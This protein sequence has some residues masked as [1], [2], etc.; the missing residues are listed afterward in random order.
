M[1]GKFL[2]IFF[3]FLFFGFTVIAQEPEVKPLTLEEIKEIVESREGRPLFVNIWATWCLP[4]KEEFPDIVKLYNSYSGEVDFLSISVDYPDEIESKILPFLKKLN[5]TFPVAVYSE[6]D[7]EKL[8]NFFS[9]D[10]NGAVP[11][12]FIFNN[13]S[14]MNEAVI[15]KKDYEFFETKLKLVLN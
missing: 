13:K 3:L 4:C 7:A 9:K 10:W 15:G 5:V 2:K 1:T 8:I 6:K 11:A 14:E 12:T